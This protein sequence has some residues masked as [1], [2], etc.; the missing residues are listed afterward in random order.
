MFLTTGL[1]NS[2]KFNNELSQGHSTAWEPTTYYAQSIYI[3]I[4][5]LYFSFVLL[6]YYLFSLYQSK[7][8][9]TP[10]QHFHPWHLGDLGRCRDS[11][12]Q[13]SQPQKTSKCGSHSAANIQIYSKNFWILFYYLPVFRRITKNHKEKKAKILFIILKHYFLFSLEPNCR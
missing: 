4:F 7:M 10:I 11:C 12:S 6:A 5:F 8:L 2:W 13:L 3:Y 9:S 1:K